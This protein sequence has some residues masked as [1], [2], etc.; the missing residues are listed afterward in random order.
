MR[1]HLV[2]IKNQCSF[3]KSLSVIVV[4]LVLS[5]SLCCH[6]FS[7]YRFHNGFIQYFDY[8]YKVVSW[9]LG[10]LGLISSYDC[11]WAEFIQVV[12][13]FKYPIFGQV[14][15]SRFILEIRQNFKLQTLIDQ[16]RKSKHQVSFRRQIDNH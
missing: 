6:Y 7:K 4:S 12:I 16:S 14:I 2:S 15:V 10:R 1:F 3:T 13:W 8:T 9:N 5:T 11:T